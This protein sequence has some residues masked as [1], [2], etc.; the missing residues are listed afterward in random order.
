M[1]PAVDERDTLNEITE[2]VIGAA[3]EIHRVIGLGLLQSAYETCLA[4]EL[5]ERGLRVEQQKSRPL[6]Y[7]NVKLD[8]GYRLNFLIRRSGHSRSQSHRAAQLCS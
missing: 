5:R 8:C 3:I 7:K 4:F 2:Q 6:I 1:D